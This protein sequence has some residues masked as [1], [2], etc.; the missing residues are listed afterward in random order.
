MIKSFVGAFWIPRSNQSSNFF[1]QHMEVAT[2]DQHRE[3]EKC[4]IVGSTGPPFLETLINLSPPANN[5]K[6]PFPVCNGYS[7]IL[8]AVDYVEA[9]ATKTNDAKVVVDFL[10]SNIFVCL[11]C[12]KL[13]SVNKGATSATEPC[14]LYSTNMGWC[15]K[16]PQHTTFRQ[17]TKQKYLIGKSREHY[18]RWRIPTRRTG[19]DSLRM[20]SKHTRQHIGLCWGCLP[21]GLSSCNKAYDQADKERKLQL[22]ELEELWL[23][24]YENSWIY[25]QKVK[26]FHDSQILRRSSKLAK[27]LKL[28]AGKLCSKWDEPFVISNVF[29]YGVV[30]LK[31]EITNSIFQ[32]NKHQLKIFHEGQVLIVGEME[33]ISLVEPAMPDETP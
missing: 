18:K 13:S 10:K 17:M 19:A 30:E 7:Y 14:P 5:V 15:T 21:T 12:R 32:V 26:Q 16:L 11:V 31:D 25:K 33:S 24:A 2:I 9:I 29:P 8:L 3:P 23:E 20:C 4:L 1:M 27:K 28:L 6:E 22:Q